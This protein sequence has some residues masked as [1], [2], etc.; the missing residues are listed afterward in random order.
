MPRIGSRSQNST[1][2]VISA[3]T[4]ALRGFEALLE[5][6]PLSTSDSELLLALSAWHLYPRLLVLS[7]ETKQVDFFDALMPPQG[8]LTLGM[9]QDS[10]EVHEPGFRWSLA[11]SRLKSYGD[12][13]RPA[14]KDNN[15][16]TMAELEMVFLGALFARWQLEP[17]ATLESAM[18]LHELG[19]KISQNPNR[20]T[21]AWIIPLL[22]AASRYVAGKPA[23]QL[24]H[25]PGN[26]CRR[27]H[28]ARTAV[29]GSSK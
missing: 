10:E 16:I 6:Q 22:H 27:R 1:H 2:Q 15:R 12:P 8:V 21:P 29:M 7:V 19:K 14:L 23:G 9:V 5:G 11:L 3:W 4:N 17:H 28:R 18:W 25:R 20:K 24:R 13:V 26:Q